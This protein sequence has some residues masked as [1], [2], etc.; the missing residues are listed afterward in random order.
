[1]TDIKKGLSPL[2]LRN[3]AMALML[4]DHVGLTFFPEHMWLRYVGRLA[5]PIFA[6]L[7]VEGF[8]HTR[9]LPR[10]LGRLLLLALVTDIP[11]QL[12]STG[13]FVYQPFRNV[14]WT[15][16][17]ALLA[18]WA[19]ELVKQHL[20]GWFNWLPQLLIAWAAYWLAN[21]MQ[22]DYHGLG[23]L[24]VL[25][26][27]WFRG[28]TWSKRAGQAG[29][30][31]LVNAL[32]FNL[33]TFASFGYENLLYYFSVFGMQIF[34]PQIHALWSVPII[35]LYKEE[36]G[37]PSRWIQLFQYLFYPVHMLVLGLLSYY[38]LS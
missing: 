5:F 20:K 9:N 12:M 1:M 2:F 6:F 24:M 14:V 4:V 21:L 22:T 35:W 16:L 3:L 19:I 34:S 10:Y 31:A 32:F 15:F 29:V 13:N 26:F 23:V 18:M 38:L 25:G 17:V 37:R 8:V 36:G 7:L 33:D 11:Y 28:K 30:M 27:Y